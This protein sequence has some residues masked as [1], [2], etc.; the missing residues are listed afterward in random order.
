MADLWLL[1]VYRVLVGSWRILSHM[2]S[3]NPEGGSTLQQRER[4]HSAA[5]GCA[6]GPPLRPHP[7]AACAPW[8][9]PGACA[10]VYVARGSRPFSGGRWPLV[11]CSRGDGDCGSPACG[12]ASSGC[13]VISCAGV[14]K[15]GLQHR[16]LPLASASEANPI[17]EDE[18]RHYKALFC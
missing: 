9:V 14:C 10:G 15:A 12:E 7:P 5:S 16:F 8:A 18:R 17:E 6:P 13:R 1:G 11:R 4:C 3:R 2:L